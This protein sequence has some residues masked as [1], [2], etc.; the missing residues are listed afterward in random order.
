MLAVL[1]VDARGRVEACHPDRR[2]LPL[3]YREVVAEIDNQ[4]HHLDVVELNGVN[5]D[6]TL[7]LLERANG[8]QLTGL[9]DLDDRHDVSKR[10]NFLGRLD[11]SGRVDLS[12]DRNRLATAAARG[13]NERGQCRDDDEW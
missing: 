9:Y 13:K 4:F 2:R 12:A 3:G 1:W 8:D 7:S 10:C 5:L 11:R 6:V